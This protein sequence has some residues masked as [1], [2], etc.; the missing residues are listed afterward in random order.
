MGDA[1]FFDW[2]AP[3][4]DRVMPPT[5]RDALE[6][7]LDLASIDVE[8]VV[9][10]AGGSGRIARE[11]DDAYDVL[12]V[13]RSHSMLAEARRH[14]LETVQGDGARLPIPDGAVDAVVIADA[15]HHLVHPD[16]VLREVHRILEPGGVLVVRDFDPATIRGRGVEVVERVF[17]FPCAFRTPPALAADLEAAGFEARV[18]DE[19]FGYTVAGVVPES[20]S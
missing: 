6:V 14:H 12:V 5:D 2:F 11:L 19:G 17:G 10:L 3:V 13:D 20:D 1:W 16:V 4:Y 15:Y 7:G 8:T 18:L 9:D